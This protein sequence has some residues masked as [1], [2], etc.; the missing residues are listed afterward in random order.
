MLAHEVIGP[1]RVARLDRAE[2]TPMVVMRARDDAVILPDEDAVRGQGHIVALTDEVTE[3]GI[4][5]GLDDALVEIDI[6][7]P[8]GSE[9]GG[10]EHAFGEDPVALLDAIL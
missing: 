3:E 8:I 2:D 5:R 4:A 9:I 10:V 7:A 1:L 6:H